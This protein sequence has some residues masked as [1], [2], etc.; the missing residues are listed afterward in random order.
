V[1]AAGEAGRRRIDEIVVTGPR[2]P[3]VKVLADLSGKG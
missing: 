2:S 3:E 1:S